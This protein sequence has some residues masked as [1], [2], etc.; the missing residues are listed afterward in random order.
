M[1]KNYTYDI[2][3]ELSKYTDIITHIKKGLTIKGLENVFSDAKAIFIHDSFPPPDFKARIA[4]LAEQKNIALVQFTGG[5]PATIWDAKKENIIRRIKKDRFYHHLIP[6]L[7]DYQ[8]NKSEQIQLQKLIFGKNYEI[9]KSLIIQDRFELF[10]S[11]RKNNFNYE[12]NITF[13]SQESKDLYELF[14]LIYSDEYEIF[15]SDFDNLMISE[16]PDA[17]SFYLKIRELVLQIQ[18]RYE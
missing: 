5:E 1:S 13:N 10:L 7:K 18:K 3:Y 11:I 15:F 17:Y 16:S 12:N 14:Y 4:F 2:I 6:F 9:E 8:L